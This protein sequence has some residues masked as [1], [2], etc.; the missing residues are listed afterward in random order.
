MKNLQESADEAD[1]GDACQAHL[2]AGGDD[3]G[4]E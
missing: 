2:R 1:R 3:F 4:K